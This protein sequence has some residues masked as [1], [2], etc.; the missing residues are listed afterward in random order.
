MIWWVVFA[1]VA[2]G[3]LGAIL[4]QVEERKGR[5]IRTQSREDER[6]KRKPCTDCEGNGRT[7]EPGTKVCT[8]DCR[9]C[10]G[11]GWVNA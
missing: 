5:E 11:T 2:L 3:I 9:R 8:G 7:Y 4:H 10:Q 6:S 1:F